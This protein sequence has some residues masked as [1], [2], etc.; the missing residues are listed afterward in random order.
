MSLRVALADPPGEPRDIVLAALRTFPEIEV[1]LLDSVATLEAAAD[2]QDIDILVVAIDR[3]AATTA[4]IDRI[5]RSRRLPIVVLADPGDQTAA[6]ALAAGALGVAARPDGG[7]RTDRQFVDMVRSLSTVNVITRHPPRDPRP[8]PTTR[9]DM[10]A[11][12]ASTGG[13]AALVDVLGALPERPAAPILV[14][15]HIAHGFGVGLAEWL[16]ST[17][18]QH[19]QLAMAGHRPVPGDVLLAPDGV[20]LTLAGGVLHLDDGPH[21]HGHRPSASVLLHSLASLGPAAL[22][23]VLTGMGTDGADGAVAMRGS[24]AQVL[25]Q[26]GAT[27]VVNGMPAAAVAAGAATEVLPL[28]EIGPRVARLLDVGRSR[29]T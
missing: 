9:V 8:A 1:M 27:A 22:A 25:C 11:V 16:K 12:V 4:A 26:D 14:V 23:V 28:P 19:V 10:V 7:G 6:A 20:H 17:A 21:V 3:L 13:P 15:Q 18:P 5:V 2:T 29:P 24:G